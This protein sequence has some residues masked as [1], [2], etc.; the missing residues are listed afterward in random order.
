[1]ERYKVMYINRR[2]NIF[3]AY[4]YVLPHI[5]PLSKL[6]INHANYTYIICKK[7][8]HDFILLNE[9]VLKKCNFISL[10]PFFEEFTKSE[11]YSDIV[12]MIQNELFVADMQT[13]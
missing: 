6:P 2:N 9:L 5:N 3:F 12:E 8:L 4:K 10:S 13:N 7:A 1:M 11:A